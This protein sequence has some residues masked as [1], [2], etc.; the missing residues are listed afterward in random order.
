M[1]P[2]INY[3]AVVIA[4]VAA[5]LVGALWYA[6][7]VFGTAWMRLTKVQPGDSGRAVRPMLVA[8]VVTFLSAWVLAGAAYIAWQF[9]GGSFVTSSLATAAFLWVGFTAARFVMHDAFER[10]PAVLTAINL[11]HELVAFLVMALIIGIWPPAGA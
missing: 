6:P 3:L 7:R 9:Y 4:T 8:L 2:E 10:R 1:V 11:G 5:M